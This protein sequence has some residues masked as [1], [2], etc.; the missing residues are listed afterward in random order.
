MYTLIPRVTNAEQVE[1][2]TNHF[3]SCLTSVEKD[4]RHNEQHIEHAE[5]TSSENINEPNG[6]I[7]PTSS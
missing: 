3:T 5:K 7:I 4:D 2:F 1:I 6:R